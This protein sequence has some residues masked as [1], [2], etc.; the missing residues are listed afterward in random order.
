MKKN[1]IPTTDGMNETSTRQRYFNIR[2]N[3]SVVLSWTLSIYSKYGSLKVFP[4]SEN[5]CV[6]TLHNLTFI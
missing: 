2:R 6:H 4:S 3:F 1:D 5:Q